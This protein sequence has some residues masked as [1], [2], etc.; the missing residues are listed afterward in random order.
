MYE[1]PVFPGSYILLRTLFLKG[2]YLVIKPQ[3]I[4]M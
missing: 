2:N 3:V 1:E 4:E